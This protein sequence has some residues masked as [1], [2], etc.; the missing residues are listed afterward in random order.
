MPGPNKI[1]LAIVVNGQETVIEGN[2]NAP[3]HTVVAKAL[4]QTGNVGQGPED[5]ELRDESGTLLDTDAKI[6]S[7]GFQPGTRLFLNPKV[8]IGGSW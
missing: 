8:G 5:W 7:Y 6:E 3:L 4:E 1:P 2:L